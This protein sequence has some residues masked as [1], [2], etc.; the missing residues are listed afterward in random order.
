MSTNS[1]T[2]EQLNEISISSRDEINQAKAD[3]QAALERL[4]AATKRHLHAEALLSTDPVGTLTGH[5]ASARTT[6]GGGFSATISNLE[7]EY[8]R[9]IALGLINRDQYK[10]KP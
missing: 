6:W 3:A 7:G 5:G 4:H 2:P 8:Q 1:L 10:R 9:E